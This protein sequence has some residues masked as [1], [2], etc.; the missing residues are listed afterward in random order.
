[1]YVLGDSAISKIKYI[2]KILVNH[3]AKY[4]K[5]AWTFSNMLNVKA[6]GAVQV[7]KLQRAQYLKEER[8]Q[9]A[10]AAAKGSMDEA[11]VTN[12][13]I[14]SPK[15]REAMNS[16]YACSESA[17]RSIRVAKSALTLNSLAKSSS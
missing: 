3:F 9:V 10:D 2:N 1:M 5:D 15:I 12:N 4:E 11:V 14:S 7:F 6:D 8:Q 13:S 17:V 16:A